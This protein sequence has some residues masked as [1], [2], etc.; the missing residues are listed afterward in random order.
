MRRRR[1]WLAA[2]VILVILLIAGAVYL[3]KL[4]APEVARLLPESEGVVYASFSGF[5]LA[6]NFGTSPVA[7]SR[8]PEYETFVR[9][10]GFQFERDLDEVAVAVHPAEATQTTFGLEMQRRYSEIF[11]ARFDSSKLNHYL[12]QLA[13]GVEKYRN[14]EIF[15][16]PHDGRT[17]RVSILSV[18]L[19]AVS[20]TNDPAN[21]KGMIDRHQKIAMPFGGP[22]LL[23]EYY[24]QVPL[25][26]SAWAIIALPSSEGRGMSLPLP[27]GID[28]KLPAETVTVASLRYLGAIQ[29]K[30]ESFTAS[31]ADAQ[32]LTDSLSNFLQLFRAVET[33]VQPGGGDP[34]VKTFFDSLKVEQKDSRAILTAELPPGF[35]KKA[36]TDAPATAAPPPEKAPPATS[37]S[38][39][40]KK[41]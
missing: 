19:V 25:G 8:E 36:M 6:S 27:N 14:F 21:I 18:D 2:G 3:R 10:T 38:K 39:G 1:I 26:S 11:K 15:T 5:R 31:E 22:R 29:F 37:K 30:A 20:N 35:I 33:N 17:V 13:S 24:R 28:F 16:I 23:S 7:I 9:Q 40:K 32:Q 34:D 12:H 4:A 41:K